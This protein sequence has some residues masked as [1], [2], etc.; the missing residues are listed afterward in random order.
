MGNSAA[1]TAIFSGPSSEYQVTFENGQVTVQD[2][3]DNRDGLN[4]LVGIEQLKF[5]DTTMDAPTA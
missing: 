3:Q 2:L 1:N 4:I 5:N